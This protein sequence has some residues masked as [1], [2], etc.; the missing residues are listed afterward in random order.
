MPAVLVR[1]AELVGLV[2]LAAQVAW[3]GV[4]VVV[5]LAG[6]CEPVAVVVGVE[7][8]GEVLVWSAVRVVEKHWAVWWFVVKQ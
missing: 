6:R 2:A 8:G 3:D 4:W 1:F 5:V 7:F